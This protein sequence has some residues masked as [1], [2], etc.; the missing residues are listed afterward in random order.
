MLNNWNRWMSSKVKNIEF[1]INQFINNS[2]G[3]KGGMYNLN[4]IICMLYIFLNSNIYFTIIIIIL[5]LKKDY[6]LKTSI[7]IIVLSGIVELH[8]LPKNKWLNCTW[9]QKK[10]FNKNIMHLKE[11]NV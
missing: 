5:C 4:F 11:L 2:W 9:T 6:L 3:S 7:C 1:N 10:Y 8:L